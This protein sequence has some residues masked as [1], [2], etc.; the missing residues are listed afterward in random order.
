MNLS[1]ASGY[2]NLTEEYSDVIAKEGNYSLNVVL[3]SPQ[4]NGF[5]N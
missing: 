2:F 4:A 3:A 1:M 5:Y